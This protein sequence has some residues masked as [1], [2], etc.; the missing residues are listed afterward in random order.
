MTQNVNWPRNQKTALVNQDMAD[1]KT[2]IYNKRNSLRYEYRQG[3][4]HI[5]MDEEVMNGT[6][7]QFTYKITITN[8]SEIDYTGQNG[9]LGYTY[10]TGQ[11]SS[12]DR[13]VTTTVNKIVDYVDNSLTFRIDDN[14]KWGW[15]LIENME[16]FTRDIIQTEPD[17]EP[18]EIMDKGTYIE[19][20][21]PRF[22]EDYVLAN[23]EEFEASYEIYKQT[24]VDYKQMSYGLYIETMME[25]YGEDYV[26]DYL[27]EFEN[28]Y[29]DVYLMTGS[30]APIN[31]YINGAEEEKQDDDEIGIGLANYEVIKSMKDRDIK[32]DDIGYL[33]ESLRTVKTKSATTVEEPITQIIVTRNLEAEP[34]KPGESASVELIL[35]K[36]LSPQDK[37]DTLN[38]GNMAE[39]LQYSNLV[40]RRDMDTIPG[41]QNPDEDPYEYDT[42]FTERILITPPYGE[43]KA[44]Y[45]VLGATILA[46]LTAGIILIKKKVLDN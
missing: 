32:N 12:S 27:D 45:I 37:D 17:E 40:G 39:I 41:N 26:F 36:T 10:Y 29:Y 15:D 35:S 2:V 18:V 44:I 25:K 30:L 38:Y 24:G 8:K 7:I 1:G 16:E 46:I 28:Q 5:Y 4:A 11:V 13:I 20:M 14:S 6:S 43:N 22:G 9:D 42:D 23:L 31:G 33:N 34:L 19:S 21:Y 3:I